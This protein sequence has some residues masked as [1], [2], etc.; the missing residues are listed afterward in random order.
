M[1]NQNEQ[2]NRIRMIDIIRGFCLLGILVANMLAFQYG[3]Y[4]QAELQ[5]FNPS[6]M[7]ESLYKVLKI[8]V[9]GSFAPIFMSLFGYGL[10]KLRGSLVFRG[11]KPELPL[12]RRFLMLLVLG[13]L[14]ILLLWEGDI[15]LSY[16]AGGFC[17]L[18]FI[19]RKP[20]SLV[21]W[22]IILSLF[23]FGI[24]YGSEMVSPVEEAQIQ[25]Y[26][27]HSISVY[28]EGTYKDISNFRL[29]E[30]PL[31]IPAAITILAMFFVPLIL[32]PMFLLGIAAANKKWF[33][34]PRNERRR[35]GWLTVIF[36]PLGLL[37]KAIAVMQSDWA[38]SSAILAAG[39]HV[40]ALGYIFGLAL[41]LSIQS[42]RS[43]VIAAFESVG[44]MS[45]T[46]YLMQTVICTTIF[47]GYG[48]GWFGEIGIGY[49][50]LLALVIYIVQAIASSYVLRKY[51]HGPIERLLRMW[52]YWSL[53]GR[54]RVVVKS[55]DAT[56]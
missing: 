17:L 7:D 50:L 52:T 14:H 34:E 53:D 4:G 18:L 47:Y 42:K 29:N 40:L 43:V 22:A 49:G 51:K 54:A 37:L 1:I 46:N 30:D 44:R 15:L 56:L 35:Y 24:N 6:S 9:V 21:I 32:L 27:K 33:H 38:W 11:I 41:V 20:K 36:L 3:I 16:G 28:G 23:Y 10:Y 2:I 31:D 19:K 8:M 55:T 39:A 12:V 13:L 26:V 5:L 48:L 25:Q 45:L